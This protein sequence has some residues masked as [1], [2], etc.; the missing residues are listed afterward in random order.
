MSPAQLAKQKGWNK[1]KL[2]EKLGK[3]SARSRAI[4]DEAYVYDVSD[5]GD[6][7]RK[8]VI[9]SG[10][11]DYE[12]DPKGNV[13]GDDAEILFESE[14]DKLPYYEFFW[15]EYSGTWLRDSVVLELIEDQ[16]RVNEVINLQGKGFHWTN[17]KL[18]QTKDMTV[19]KNLFYGVRNGDVLRVNSEIT[20]IANEE[21]NLAAFR[22][23]VRNWDENVRRKSFSLESVTGE[24]LP[25][26]TPFRLGFIQQAA[27]GGYFDQKRETIGLLLKRLIVDVV[28]P[29]FQKKSR[30]EHIF[31]LYGEDSDV[32]RLE[33]LLVEFSLYSSVENF[34]NSSG[35]I[36]SE[37]EVESERQRALAKL[38]A[39]PQ[40]ELKVPEGFYNDLKYRVDIVTTN[41]SVALDAKM[42][43][44]TT[45][46]QTIATNPMILQ[47]EN[48]RKIFFKIL[49]FSGINPE[50]F[51][52][53]A[54]PQLP[55]EMMQTFSPPPAAGPKPELQLGGTEARL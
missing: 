30:K 18:Y 1:S 47:D 9:V 27:A 17:K 23:E 21:R 26:G 33:D 5:K 34:Y 50:E 2:L 46:M 43:T 35:I 14:V 20:P 29:T 32:S 7:T 39:R 11:D 41:E 54:K 31:N 53:S 25:S 13:T 48:L 24:N 38:R 6:V 49:D 44:L 12:V 40:R 10:L 28:I 3:Q 42:Q 4:I 22:E 45:I 16:M 51:R 15:D 37:E 8:L 19:A 55:P 36:P 52:S